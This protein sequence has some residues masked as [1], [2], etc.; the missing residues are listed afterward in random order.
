M[1]PGISFGGVGSWSMD[2]CVDSLFISQKV[3]EKGAR[4]NQRVI[5]KL[6]RL[7]KA[8]LVIYGVLAVPIHAT[9]ARDSHECDSMLRR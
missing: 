7:S 3:G 2:V 6:L 1:K 9:A 5:I 4:Q 8:G